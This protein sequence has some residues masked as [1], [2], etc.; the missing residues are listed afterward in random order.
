MAYIK[1]DHSKFEDAASAAD[2]Y[3]KIMKNKM[4]AAQ[5]EVAALASSWQGGDASLFR[6]KFDKLDNNDST[7][8]QMVKALDSYSQF[9]RYAAGRYKDA[10]IK[11][12]DRANDLPKW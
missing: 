10:Q 1:V 8:M 2:K 5:S 6:T 9:L 4:H 11:A 3:V 7:H 12:I